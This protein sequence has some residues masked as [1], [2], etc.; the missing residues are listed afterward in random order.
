MAEGRI[1]KYDIISQ[2]AIATVEHTI[3]KLNDLGDKMKELT[4]AVNAAQGATDKNKTSLDQLNK[5][6]DDYN[7]YEQASKDRLNEV[8]NETNKLIEAQQKAAKAKKD[9]TDEIKKS[10]KEQDIEKKLIDGHLGT[11][12]KLSIRNKQLLDERKKLNLATQEGKDKL[13]SINGELNANTE[14][15]RANSSAAEKQRME[16]GNYSGALDK[17]VPGLGNFANGIVS[18]TKASLAFIATPLGFALA[19]IAIAILAVKTYFTET[20]EA[21]DKWNKLTNETS[22]IWT[23]FRRE[24]V[25]IGADIV[26][27]FEGNGGLNVLLTQL[28][29]RFGA[30]LMVLDSVSKAVKGDFKGAFKEYGQATVQLLTGVEFWSNNVTDTFKK[31]VQEAKALS[32]AYSDLQAKRDKEERADIVETAKLQYEASKARNEA[33]EKDKLTITERIALMQIALDTEKKIMENHVRDAERDLKLATDKLAL[34]K[35]DKANLDEVARAE[36][37]LFEVRTEY[38]NGTRRIVSSMATFREKLEKEEADK[39]KKIEDDKVKNQKQTYDN[40]VFLLKQHDNKENE[41]LSKQYAKGKLTKKQYESEKLRLTIISMQA[42]IDLAKGLGQDTLALE[43]QLSKAKIAIQIAEGDETNRLQKE[44][45]DRTIANIKHTSQQFEMYAG[46]MGEALGMAIAQGREGRK[47]ALK[48]MINDGLDALKAFIRIQELTIT[49]GSLAQPD[50]ILTFGST[51]ITRAAIINGLIEAGFAAAKVVIDSSIDQLADG[52]P[53]WKGGVA[54]VGEGKSREGIRLPSG[55]RFITPDH[56]TLA[57]LPQ[58]TAVEPDLNKFLI[59]SIV[60]MPKN[61]DSVGMN[62]Q[63]IKELN[64]SMKPKNVLNVNIDEHGLE[65]FST[66]TTGRI[67]Y[68]NKKFRGRINV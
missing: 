45:D 15:I 51:G 68:I 59:E 31:N 35:S 30:V 60:E 62:N 50:S 36:A 14:I 20:E 19:A 57:Y 21:Q 55:E 26:S 47:A 39:L 38:Y 6:V 44:S 63:L 12:E 3:A 33:M 4:I 61:K 7:K 28:I 2:E 40:L 66:S 10:I 53:D 54:M 42:Q 8:S 5:A 37:K 11:L 25:K 9:L 65:I 24:F 58:H 41:E 27:V 16:I 49:A 56:A 13:H 18:M 17:I 23:V 34:N 46:R 1:E 67:N 29:N 52:T 43:D 48:E 64:K 32:D 22:A